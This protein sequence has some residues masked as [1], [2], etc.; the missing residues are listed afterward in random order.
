[1][2]E[3][4]KV[5]GRKMAVCMGVLMSFALA[6]TGNMASG[7]FA[8]PGFLI[9]FAISLLIS[10]AIG[11]LIPIGRVTQGACKGLGLGIGTLPARLVESLISDLIYTPFITLVMTGF[12]YQMVIRQS[13]GEVRPVFAMMFARSF[14]I[15]FIVGFVLIF[16][17]Q[18]IFLKL[19]M[20]DQQHQR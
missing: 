17:F 16:I 15:C 19:I 12:A 8:V 7:H 14:L 2:N 11:F 20:K 4:M 18:P 1:M 5:V 10:L 3:R 13:G 9:S 6:L